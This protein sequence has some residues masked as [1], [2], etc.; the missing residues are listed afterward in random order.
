[1]P[2]CRA[3]QV[4]IPAW[5]GWAKEAKKKLEDLLRQDAEAA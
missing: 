4:Q 3:V 2:S 5:Q 1:M